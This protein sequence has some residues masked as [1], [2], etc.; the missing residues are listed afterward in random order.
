MISWNGLA[1][2][3]R[4]REIDVQKFWSWSGDFGKRQPRAAVESVNEEILRRR[5]RRVRVVPSKKE[6]SGVQIKG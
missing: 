5:R 3:D 6:M 1:Y 2:F 4:R